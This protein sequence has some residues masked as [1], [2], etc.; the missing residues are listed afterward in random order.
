[1]GKIPTNPSVVGVDVLCTVTSVTPAT[2]LNLLGGDNITISGTNFPHALADSTFTLA[3]DDAAATSCEIQSSTTTEFV[4]LT[5]AFNPVAS[6]GASHGM[7]ITINDLVVS[8]SLSLSMRS[9]KDVGMSITPSSASPVLKGEIV[10][11]LESSFASTLAV[12]DFT[13]NA[14]LSTN[15]SVVKRMNVVAVDDAAKELTVMFGG[16]ESGVYDIT[17]RHVSAGVIG[18]GLTLSVGSTVTNVSPMTASIYGGTI[19]TIT[20]TNFGTEKTDNPVQIS[21]NGGVGSTNCYILTTM[22]TEITCQL[23]ETI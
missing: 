9:V 1:M 6:S 2:N 15:S 16:A 17:I 10:I 8:N 20:G 19:L 23:D 22:A 3:F 7:S 21:Y 5:S 14:T 12:E 18:G 11:A 4:C 13:V